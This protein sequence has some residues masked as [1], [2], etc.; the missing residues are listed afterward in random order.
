MGPVPQHY[1]KIIE[2][3]ERE[4]H[5]KSSL[6]ESAPGYSPMEIYTASDE[7]DMK[8]FDQD[9]KDILDRVI[10]KYGG[11]TGKQLEDLT[12]AEAPFVA[13]EQSEEILFDLAFYRGTD[14][15]DVVARA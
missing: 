7:P 15:S 12:H 3:L 1:T 10:K 8:V 6:S 11:L 4:G 2:E 5:L 14:F 13:T 9:D